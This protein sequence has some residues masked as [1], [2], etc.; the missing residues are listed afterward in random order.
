[1]G[2][3]GV[4]C[5]AD[6]LGFQAWLEILTGVGMLSFI[7]TRRSSAIGPFIRANGCPGLLAGILSVAGYLAYLAAAQ[8]L[9]LA[10]VSA[11]RESSVIFGTVIGTAMFKE[12][13]GARRMA[14]AVMVT[15]G[16]AALALASGR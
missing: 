14:A 5:G 6:V 16:F 2:A 8:V 9:P 13:F 12:G 3:L 7:A 10:P 11:L 15:C 1:L 4:R